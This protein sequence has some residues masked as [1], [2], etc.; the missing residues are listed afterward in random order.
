MTKFIFNIEK[1]K[2]WRIDHEG[3]DNE[4]IDFI[5]ANH[6]MKSQDGMERDELIRRGYIVLE[7]WCVEQESEGDE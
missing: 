6:H 2:C 1:Y 3:L 5:I 4:T 7:Q